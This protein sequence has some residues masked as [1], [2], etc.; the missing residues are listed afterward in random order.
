VETERVLWLETLADAC[1]RVLARRDEGD[2]TDAHWAMLLDDVSDLL[3]RIRAELQQA[4][5]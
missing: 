1:E 5:R 4:G 3:A 2:S